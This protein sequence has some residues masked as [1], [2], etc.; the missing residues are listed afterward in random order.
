MRR[1][2]ELFI[3]FSTFLFILPVSAQK[4][5]F[6]ISGK[7]IDATNESPLEFATVALLKAVDSTVI[8]GT[9]TD[10]EGSFNLSVAAGDYMLNVKFLG[11]E[12]KYITTI[13]LSEENPSFDAGNIALAEKTTTL[14]AVEITSKKSRMEFDLDKRVFN[15]GQDLSN[16]GGNASDLMDNIPSISTDIDGNVSLRGSQNVRILINGRPSGMTSGDALQQL[17]ADLIEKVEII[18]NPGARYE[19]EGTAGIINIVLKK[20]R[21]QRWNGSLNAAAGHPASHNLSAN[22]N[23]REKKLN[24]F[25]N[26]GARYRDQPREAY[27]HRELYENGALDRIVDQDE[28]SYRKG[29]SGNLRFGADYNLDEK[30]VLTGSIMYR[31]ENGDNTRDIEYLYFNNESVLQNTSLRNTIEDEDEEGL[32]YNLRFDK[33]FGKDHKLTASVVYTSESETEAM[34]ATEEFFNADGVLQDSDLLQRIENGEDEKE[35]DIR[36]DYVRPMGK[37]GKFEVGY[38][39]GIRHIDTRYKVEEFDPEFN[40]WII[41][42]D[43]SNEFDYDENIHAV[44]SSYGTDLGKFNYQIGLRTEYTDVVTLL[45]NT[46]EKNDRDYINVFPSAFLNYEVN[47]G[48]AMQVNYS[49]R[50][51]RP[52][53]W[54]LNP[55]FNYANPLSVRSGNPNLNPEFANSFE[56]SY[57]KSWDKASLSSSIYYRHTEDVIIRINRVGEDNVNR[58]MPENLATQNDVG[59]EFAL[60]MNPV[61]GWDLTLSTNVFRG[62]INGENLGFARQTVFTSWTSRLNTRFDF[63]KKYQGQIMVNYRGP[64]KTPQGVRRDFLFTDAAISRDILNKKATVSLRMSNLFNV[65]YRYEAEGEGFFLYREGQWRAVRQLYLNVTYRINQRKRTQRGGRGGDIDGDM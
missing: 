50:I 51:R 53:F 35:W 15:V 10:T 11:F 59:A 9:M 19:A 18:T 2:T 3:L 14:D 38:R 4:A 41:L 57:I 30:T 36:L 12:S 43:L 63:L 47:E 27:E 7:V 39:S 16:L 26:L 58:S 17:P 5:S 42:P 46:N 29:I 40:D 20:N 13:S 23:Y 28:I 8:T 65:K 25:A 32:D 55:F 56:V 45:R 60:N 24:W 37:D 48:N 22:I 61:Q 64:E 31:R 52:R 6:T 49:R 34:D 21:R 54:D 1:F 62:E 33:E 44:Y